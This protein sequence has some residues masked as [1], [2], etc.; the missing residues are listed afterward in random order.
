MAG[1]LLAHAVDADMAGLD[2]RGG[3]G[4]GLDHPRVPQ[5]F[6]ETLALQATPLRESIVSDPCGSAVSCSLSAA[7]L[8]NGELGSTGRSRSRGGALVAYCRCDGPLS[9][10]PLS[11]PPLST[12]ALV[13]PPPLSRPPP[14][15]PFSLGL[16]SLPFCP[17]PAL[18]LKALARRTDGPCPRAVREPARLRRCAAFDRRIGAGF[19]EIIVAVAPS[20]PVPLAL[21]RPRRPRLRRRRA[22]RL[23]AGRS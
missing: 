8:A 1:R 21:W 11:R 13:A 15:L 16:A 7:S 12:A 22:L 10:P 5:P 14:N 2:Q 9:R 4:A 6:I 3:A 17:V 23:P 18:A 19:A 20:A